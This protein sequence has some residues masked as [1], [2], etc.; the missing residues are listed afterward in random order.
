MRVG[1]LQHVHLPLQPRHCRLIRA[2]AAVTQQS[3][4][5]RISALGIQTDGLPAAYGLQQGGGE[6]DEDGHALAGGLVGEDIEDGH[7]RV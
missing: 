5:H 3:H 7:L 4:H 2:R 6:L 1:T